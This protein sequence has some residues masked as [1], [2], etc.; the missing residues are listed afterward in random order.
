ACGSIA[1]P[2]ADHA[3]RL[4]EALHRI[5]ELQFELMSSRWLLFITS[6][7]RPNSLAQ[8]TLDRLCDAIFE[9]A[10]ADEEFRHSATPLLGADESDI[11][12]A[13][14]AASKT[15]GTTFLQLFSLGI[16]KWLL[17]LAH[18]KHWDM[19]THHPFCYSTMPVPN[20]TPSM[21][22]LAFE[23]VP[24][25]AGLQDRFGVSRAVP[26]RNTE[27][28]DTALR[29]VEKIGGMA[30]ADSRLRSDAA[31]RTRV[32]RDLRFWLEEAGYEAS[33]LKPLQA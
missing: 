8:E 16:A 3:N 11:R 5:V 10:E 15:P 6:D 2:A 4:I 29:A 14:S 17:H 7:V 33:A 26:A 28:E 31:L 13:A 27:L 24:P 32:T 22:C 19:K 30:N 23:F 1:A 25:P 9:N 20:D 12:A 21:A 18:T